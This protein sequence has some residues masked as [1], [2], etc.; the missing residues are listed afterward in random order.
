MEEAF[1]LEKAQDQD[2]QRIHSLLELLCT[3]TVGEIYCLTLW[4]AEGERFPDKAF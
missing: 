3:E 2:K 4:I 1:P